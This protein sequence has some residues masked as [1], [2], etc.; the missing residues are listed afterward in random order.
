[1]VSPTEHRVRVRVFLD[2]WNFTL[3]LR[4]AEAGFMIDWQPLGQC[5]AR[6]AL[7]TVDPTARVAYQGMSVYSS[8]NPTGRNDP[9]HRW[10]M[11]TLRNIPGVYGTILPRQRRGAGPVC[12]ACHREIPECPQC[13][14]DLRGT[15]EKGVDTAMVTDMISL[16]WTDNYDVAVL[17]SSDQDFIPVAEFLQTRGVKVVHGAFP[18]RASRLTAACW[19]SVAIPQIRE[20][21]RRT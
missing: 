5:L 4:Q 18:P 13:G 2:Y 3:D 12:P 10:F 8:Y 7:L 14:S 6:E 15:E 16:A 19:G 21:F 20:Q 9:H 1:M 11:N 17:V